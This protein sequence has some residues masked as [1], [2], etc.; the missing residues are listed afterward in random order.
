[1]GIIHGTFTQDRCSSEVGTAHREAPS[2]LDEA[3]SLPR[4]ERRAVPGSARSAR[5]RSANSP[6][7]RQPTGGPGRSPANRVGASAGRRARPGDRR[8]SVPATRRVRPLALELDPG[9]LWANNYCGLRSAPVARFR[10]GHVRVLLRASPSCRRPRGATPIAGCSAGRIRPFRCSC[11]RL[12]PEALALDP[13]LC[14]RVDRAG[15]RCITAPAF[16]QS[17][18]SPA[19][20]L[21][22][23]GVSPATVVYHTAAVHLAAGDRNAATRD[24]SASAWTSDPSHPEATAA[25]ARLEAN[26]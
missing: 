16:V 19:A 7:P 2:V 21:R 5:V 23:A 18:H 6:V 8:P 12:R 25:L 1:M 17:A 24:A 11:G 4:S 20:M 15:G 14:S 26:H 22:D 13:E 3:E 10:R 9:S